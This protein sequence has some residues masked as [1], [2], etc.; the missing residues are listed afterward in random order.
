MIHV[1]LQ[2]LRR[3]E[4][5]P[6]ATTERLEGVDLWECGLGCRRHLSS[7]RPDRPGPAARDRSQAAKERTAVYVPLNLVR[8]FERAPESTVQRV[9]GEDLWESGLFTYKN[10]RPG[11]S[12]N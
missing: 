2:Q 5:T 12:G 8:R 9:N 7:H 3:F 10:P 11:D 6:E 1:P 4:R